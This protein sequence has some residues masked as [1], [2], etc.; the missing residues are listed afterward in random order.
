[1]REVLDIV[2]HQCKGR[3]EL[4]P[5]RREE[6]THNYGACMRSD[7]RTHGSMPTLYPITY[8]ISLT[9]D[10]LTSEFGSAEGGE[11]QKEI[12]RA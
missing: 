8:A 2:L 12:T 9:A 4:P 7:P 6:H 10:G 5:E 1:M 3:C 11:I